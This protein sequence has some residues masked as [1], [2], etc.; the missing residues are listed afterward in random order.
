M[1]YPLIVAVVSFVLT[2]S[3]AAGANPQRSTQNECE[4]IALG[5]E[6][7]I[8]RDKPLGFLERAVGNFEAQVQLGD[9]SAFRKLLSDQIVREGSIEKI[10][11]GLNDPRL[12]SA[13]AESVVLISKSGDLVK[14]TFTSEVGPTRAFL[15][16]G[17]RVYLVTVL[18]ERAVGVEGSAFVRRRLSLRPE[19]DYQEGHEW[20]ALTP[21]ARLQLNHEIGSM[22]SGGAHYREAAKT[23]TLPT[24][25]LMP[26]GHA[27]T[28]FDE[29]QFRGQE[30]GRG[31]SWRDESTGLIWSAASE[32]SFTWENAMAA[33]RKHGG[34]I[35]SLEELEEWVGH[36]GLDHGALN[37]LFQTE[38]RPFWS[39][40]RVGNQLWH[41]YFMDGATGATDFRFSH[42]SAKKAFRCVK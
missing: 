4:L 8:L 5:S 24:R 25:V 6:S 10:S 32:E 23:E 20:S 13:D 29:P 40:S 39:S 21:E 34:R 9:R 16:H 2:A 27:F 33:C 26:S 17:S 14:L 37:A 38:A 36:L 12:Q 15:Q 35:P 7:A 18:V 1:L 3:G 31:L 42:Y 11:E 30:L 19:S 28:Q 22:P 41:A